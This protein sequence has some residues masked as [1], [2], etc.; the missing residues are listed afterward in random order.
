[1]AVSGEALSKHHCLQK[2][3]SFAARRW[4]PKVVRF[5]AY[6][7]AVYEILHFISLKGGCVAA[8]DLPGKVADPGEYAVA[9]HTGYY[10]TFRPLG[11]KFPLVAGDHATNQGHALSIRGQT[12]R[13]HPTAATM[14]RTHPAT[15]ADGQ[16][17]RCHQGPWRSRPA[18]RIET[19]HISLSDENDGEARWRSQ[20]LVRQS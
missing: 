5:K 18:T 8:L 19:T 11:A 10:A 4:R 2:R 20:R 7:W 14:A 17:D 9:F 16:S 12:D 13:W 3:S 6:C 1:M 15:S